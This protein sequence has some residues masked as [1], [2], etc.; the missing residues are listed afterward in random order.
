MSASQNRSVESSGGLPVPLIILI[1]AVVVLA[2]GFL[3]AH[4]L[5]LEAEQ[6]ATVDELKG[7]R[8]AF[9]SGRG[10]A[11]PAPAAQV[12]APPRVDP[13]T[14]SLAVNDSASRGKADAKLTLVEF[15]DFEC[16]FCGRYMKETYGLIQHDYVDS[17][18]IRYVFRNFPLE[19]IH[20][21]AL[22][23][24]VAGE[25]ARE[26]GKFWDMHDRL[27]ANQQALEEPDLLKTAAAAGV[28]ASAFKQCLGGRGETKIRRDLDDGARAGITGT[29]YFFIGVTQPDGKVK[30]MKAITGA[31]PYSVFKSTIDQLLAQPS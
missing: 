14:V 18:K 16:P 8:Q 17:G 23:A 12:Q 15:S 27:F 9:E 31:Q 26:Q 5:S 13:T 2:F 11:G 25:C 10:S 1:V 30:V 7:I 3:A 20:P 28:D 21:H 22:R 29:P 24:G 19:R 6:R 4:I